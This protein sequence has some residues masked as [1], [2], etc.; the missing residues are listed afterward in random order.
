MRSPSALCAFKYIP[1]HTKDFSS[2]S[3]G[4]GR[5]TP[6]ELVAETNWCSLRWDNLC[7]L[8]CR[9]P[10]A[11]H[12]AATLWVCA[13]SA[14]LLRRR[15]RDLFPP[16]CRCLPR[17]S[18]PRCWKSSS[19]WAAEALYVHSVH[20]LLH[21][22]AHSHAHTE[23]TLQTWKIH[24][25]QLAFPVRHFDNN[26][27]V[28]NQALWPFFSPRTEVILILLVGCSRENNPI[29]LLVFFPSFSFC[30]DSVAVLHGNNLKTIGFALSHPLRGPPRT[31]IFTSRLY[32]SH[33]CVSVSIIRV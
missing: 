33:S 20:S 10:D 3:P 6:C 31:W 23:S 26:C 29:W 11:A 25:I 7:I 28:S 8:K 24:G 9:L 22:H 13:A 4:H 21:T 15:L 17:R 32:T 16:R 1:S 12:G 2:V 14:M 30:T 27:M 5:I 19:P 18:C